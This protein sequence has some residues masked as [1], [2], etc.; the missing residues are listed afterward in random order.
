MSKTARRL[1]AT[2]ALACALGGVARAQ[3][4]ADL[5]LS[6]HR[7]VFD[8]ER[9]AT[10]YLFNR[11]DAPASYT[12][13]LVDRV[14]DDSGRISDAPE[15]WPASAAPFLQHTPRRVTLGPRES[16]VIRI[17][18][19]P[20]GLGA[21]AEYRTHLTVTATPPETAGLTAEAASAGSDGDLAFNV[22][23]LFSMSIP[24]IV[25]EGPADARAGIEAASLTGAQE[26]APHGAVSL[27]LVRLGSSS[28]FGD[29]LV[30]AGDTVV[31]QIKGVAVYPEIGRRQLLIPLAQ[32]VRGRE[33]SVSYVDDDVHPGVVLATASVT[34]VAP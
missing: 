24:L 10:V 27:D 2:L 31:A 3:V 17:R 1:A 18:L 12:V 14:M 19:R 9:S 20:P 30:R 7:V 21:P 28:V 13:G 25:R 26:G 15:A 32:A 29:V 22:I 4:G 33:L 8:D 16:Q 5:N 11:G 6:P 34:A 23:A